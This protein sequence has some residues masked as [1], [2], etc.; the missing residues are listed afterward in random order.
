MSQLAPTYF[1][2]ALARL[3]PSAALARITSRA[4][5]EYVAEAGTESQRAIDA[6]AGDGPAPSNQPE[7]TY[8]TT[9]GGQGGWYKRW[10]TAPRDAASDVLPHL[11]ELRAQ[12]RDLVRKE[13]YARSALHTKA[14]R[15]VGTGLA[16]S[17][18]PRRDVLGWNEEQANA[19]RQVTHAE[20]SLFADSTQSDWLGQ[21]DVYDQQWL[22]LLSMLESGDSFT[23]LPDGKPTGTMPYA[24]RTQVIEADRVGNPRNMADSVDVAGGV[25]RV[26]GRVEYYVYSRHPGSLL[27]R[28]MPWLYDGEWIAAV[29]DSG[30]RRILHHTRVERP[31]QPRGLPDLTCVMALFKQKAIYTDAEIKAAIANAFIALIIENEGGNGPAPVF[32]LQN[33]SPN[34]P[35][36]AQVPADRIEL[37]PAAV[38]GLAKGEKGTAFDPKRPNAMFDKFIA[39]IVDQLGAGTLLGPEMLAKKY[40]TSYV[41]ARAAFLDAWT[42]LRMLRRK[43]V[44]TF[45]QP[46]YETWMA[47]AVILGRVKAPGFFRDP[48][49]RWAYTRAAWIGD[50]QGSINPKDEVKAYADAIEARLC[51]RE[52][53]QWELFGTDWSETYDTMKAEH[54]R[55]EGDG[56]LPVPKA[57]AAAPQE[58]AGDE[59]PQQ[60]PAQDGATP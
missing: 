45:C 18:Q 16:L 5:F 22:V 20:W 19:W 11:R 32:G 53:A 51:T 56:M 29:G 47:E 46:L 52:R 15:A 2:R 41:A 44:T 7:G 13:A 42:H 6:M 24:L 35:G 30:R 26:D 28:S 8:A 50:S 54:V 48:L 3:S 12:S 25:R 23:V 4:R 60:T 31:E 10:F 49:L 9:G 59:P 14:N 57:G 40:N 58:P 38:L 37:G 33:P 21:S 55:L 17:A 27:F 1:E 34:D 43:V 36:S 39:A